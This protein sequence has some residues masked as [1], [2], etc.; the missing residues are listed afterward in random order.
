M[1]THLNHVFQLVLN[2]AKCFVQAKCNVL[3]QFLHRYAAQQREPAVYT[4]RTI[5][6]AFHAQDIPTR[7]GKEKCFNFEM[8]SFKATFNRAGLEDLL[9]RRFFYAPSFSIYNGYFPFILEFRV[10]FFPLAAL[11]R[12][13]TRAR[14]CRSLRLRPSRRC[15]EAEPAGV[16]ASPLCD[17][18]Q[19]A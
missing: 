3:L 7:A 13:L 19:H 2:D 17:R 4:K 1:F 12:F 9:K 8:S 10:E 11:S 16:L 6:C 14:H 15:S 5:E 18:G